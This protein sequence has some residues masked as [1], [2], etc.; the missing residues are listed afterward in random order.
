MESTSSSDN[1]RQSRGL[2][3]FWPVHGM[4]A[5]AQR[6][7]EEDGE[8]AVAQPPA[9]PGEPPRWGKFAGN[10][11]PQMVSRGSRRAP[12]V[13]NGGRPYANQ[14]GFPPAEAERAF[15]NA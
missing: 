4:P 10:E 3:R 13:V 15:R 1:G 7:S 9:V 6:Q 11:D 12:E 2:A 8:D 14:G 5:P